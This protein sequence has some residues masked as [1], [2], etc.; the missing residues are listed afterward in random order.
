MTFPLAA[1]TC[2][3]PVPA[4]SLMAYSGGYARTDLA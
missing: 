3:K 4:V 1:L 2:V